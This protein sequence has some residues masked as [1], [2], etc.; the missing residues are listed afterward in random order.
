MGR[1][2]SGGSELEA[3]GIAGKTRTSVSGRSWGGQPIGRGGLYLLLQNRIYRGEIERGAGIRVKNPSL[4]G[5]LLF[6][7]EGQRMTPTHAVK[8]SKR[9]RYY[10]S[11]PLI[12]GARADAS[13]GLRLPARSFEQIVTDRIRRLLAQPASLFEMLEAQAGEPTLQQR[14]MARAAELAGEWALMSA[15]R[16]RVIPL[17]LVRRWISVPTG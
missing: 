7:S 10:V 11:R 13:A 2:K 8:S 5:G 4:L 6:D 1:T 9:Y 12:V 14:L 16:M 17:A 3:H 15:L